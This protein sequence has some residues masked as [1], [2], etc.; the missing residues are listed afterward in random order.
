MKFN[1]DTVYSVIGQALVAPSGGNSPGDASWY[2]AVTSKVVSRYGR[3][4]AF[5]RVEYDDKGKPLAAA[6][7]AAA[8]NDRGASW[9]ERLSV[10]VAFDSSNATADTAVTYDVCRAAG[11]Q[12]DVSFIQEKTIGANN[13]KLSHHALQGTFPGI[14]SAEAKELGARIFECGVSEGDYT[15]LFYRL[16]VMISDMHAGARFRNARS[17][18]DGVLCNAMMDRIW[19]R[20]AGQYAGAASLLSSFDRLE[21]SYYLVGWRGN[22]RLTPAI[23]AVLACLVSANMGLGNNITGRNAYAA[24]AQ[25][26][27]RLYLYLAG[28]CSL[29]SCDNAC[30]NAAALGNPTIAGA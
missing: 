19:P 24:D 8:R 30:F 3:S 25:F 11:L 16:I 17:A 20:A 1:T 29:S 18:F 26:S 27:D 10:P 2:S 9:T 28:T 21:R 5:A 15:E 14:T 13:T 7:A 4:A 23:M 22:R 6:A 12:G